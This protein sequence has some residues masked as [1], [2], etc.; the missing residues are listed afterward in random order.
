M[1]VVLMK[2]LYVVGWNRNRILFVDVNFKNS[3]WRFI[4]I[5]IILLFSDKKLK[6]NINC[7]LVEVC[8]LFSG[9]WW[10]N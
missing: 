5:F 8:V 9:C 2:R 6:L 1:I 7:W 3:F 4:G 10:E